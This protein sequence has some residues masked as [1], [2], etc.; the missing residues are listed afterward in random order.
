MTVLFEPPRAGD[1]DYHAH[2]FAAN[3]CHVDNPR[4][5]PDYDATVDQYLTALREH[6]LSWGT[7][8]QPSFLGHDNTFMIDAMKNNPGYF[9]GVV[10]V[11][12]DDPLASSGDLS[13]WHDLGVRGVRINHYTPP[14]PDLTR[15][16]WRTF[17]HQ[18]AEMG[19]FMQ[20]FVGAA[21]LRDLVGLI[22]GLP[23]TVVIDHLGL[24]TDTD[25]SSHPLMDLC[26]LPNLWV[27]AS[28]AYRCAPGAAARMY[29]ELRGRGFEN[30]VPGS[31]WP[32]TQFV[33]EPEGA[34]MF[35][36]N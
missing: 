23:C 5:V 20:F 28:G 26:E 8:V 13:R 21:Q 12:P 2:V 3:E 36:G 32:H 11:D 30:I 25:V 29:D 18:L 7:I 6:A 10:C 17:A 22:R 24:P 16:D 15:A 35:F 34:W 31:D 27:K 4:Y 33:G 1:G 19:W 14:M 9:R